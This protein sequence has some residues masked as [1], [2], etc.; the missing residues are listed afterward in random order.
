MLNPLASADC[1]HPKTSQNNSLYQPQLPAL[2]ANEWRFY[3]V[4][5]LFWLVLLLALA[6][7]VLATI[8]NPPQSAQP[9]KELLIS[10]TKLLMMLQP[11][12]VG[13]LAPLAFLRD[14]Q[15]GMAEL[16]GVTP[17]SQKQWC[18]SRAGGLLLLT[19]GFQL[20]LLILAA[21]A[22]WGGMQPAQ[23]NFSLGA[24]CGISILLFLL[25][26][27][28]ALLLLVAL[29]LWCSRHTTQIALLYLLTACC[30]I[31]YMLLAAAN[32]SPVMAKS[33]DISP[34]LSQL[35]FYLDPY[36][37]TPWLAQ[38][39]NSASI[40][41][42]AA[43]LLN[44]LLIVSLSIL[45]VWRALAVVSSGKFQSATQHNK[46][47][48]SVLKTEPSANLQAQS[49]RSAGTFTPIP[50]V[51]CNLHSLIS[52]IRLQWTQLLRQ[53]STVLALLVLSGLVFSEV[54]TGLSYAEPQSQLQPD[55]R[56]ALNRINWDLLPRFGLLLLA[57]WASQLSWLNRQLRCDSLIATSPVSGWVQLG[58]QLVVLW[59][60]TLL[61]VL[62]SFSGVAFAQMLLQIPIE[63]AEYQQQGLFV[64]LPLLM[65]GMLL[66]ACH[67]LLKSP[68]RANVLVFVLLLLALSPLPQLLELSHP[69]W[70]IGQTQLQMPDALWAYQA[71]V[72]A[73]GFG[74]EIKQGGFWPY[75]L[76]WTLLALSFW[77]LA[78][79]FYHR[80]TG[81]SAP[82]LQLNTAPLLLAA[83]LALLWL[84]QGLDIHQQLTQA[85]ALETTAQRQAERA[86][87]E[88]QY[89]HWQ[90]QPQPVVSKVQLQ[91]RLSPLEQQAD[92]Q[93]KLT[94]HNPHPT[95]ITDL[96]LTL[97]GHLADRQALQQIRFESAQLVQQP[98]G[99]NQ[100]VYR[101]KQALAPGKSTELQLQL[102]L[103]QQA[104][105]PAP[106][107]Q[108][109]RPEFSYLRLLHVL[110]QPGFMPE[111]RLKDDKSR[112]KFGLTPLPATE[113]QPSV[114]AATA[115]PANARYD[116]AQLETVVSVPDGYQAVAA[117]KLI[118]QWR[119]HNLQYF[120]YQTT[121]AIRN[122]PA[123]VAVP[124]QAKQQ[125]QQGVSLEI[126]S[127]YFNKNTDLTMQAL[128]QTLYWFHT[129]IGPYPGDALRLVMMPDIGPTGYAL[130]QLVLIN[131]RVG[132]RA[133]AA[134][135]AGFS[136]VYRRAVHEMAHQWFGHGIGNGVPGDG[137]FLVESLAKYA[138]LVLIEQHF[139][140]QAMLA[141]VDFEQQR[142]QRAMAGSR[143]EQ[144]SLIDADES[145]DQYSRA[146]LM[147]ALLRAELGDALITQAL[148]QLWQQHRYPAKPASAMDFVRILLALS[149]ADKH[150]VI[151]QLLLEADNGLLLKPE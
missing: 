104:I 27:V 31:G 75:W 105:A 30:F 97:P 109:L 120:Q 17:L 139:G 129:K 38:L 145:Y 89:Q 22:V 86:A 123:V 84:T 136:Q 106:I 95:A 91:I 150:G 2:L 64:L 108:V 57:L 142:Y 62:L 67:A 146:T 115:T 151:Q 125:Q 3:R 26:Q 14:R 50:P 70:Q 28:P 79:Q 55:S 53:R 101:F 147:F 133:F 72:G 69:L 117:G 60:L 33:G 143:A 46:P 25:Q 135:D 83:I 42:G 112:A 118:R 88:Q 23:S 137:A 94:L 68:V 51:I 78:L 113:T 114:L 90:Q 73:G 132:L 61:L 100:P 144:K 103:S 47:R 138:E 119:E 15:Y 110:P 49:G 92:I 140:Q 16:T 32:G 20:L 128:S 122:L 81:F 52:L 11:L 1:L 24:L 21:A 124:W 8:G 130:P 102:K 18:L 93:A 80:G 44:R 10:H 4:Q 71:S 141:L 43:V 127:P 40:S 12:F 56:D 6:F 66:L 82:K 65:W 36:A 9:H 48:T 149:P 7:A 34:L 76:F 41:P 39:Q 13:V 29:Q 74:G 98:A 58:S 99:Y 116:W 54:F 59:L 35:M 63:A 111:L 126:Y 45:L 107:H 77:F 19:L 148:Q 37:L 131:H 5:P 85:G 134:P 121:D 87:Y 96:L